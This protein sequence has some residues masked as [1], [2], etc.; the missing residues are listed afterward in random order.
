M[1]VIEPVAFD[2]LPA[3][4]AQAIERNVASR[5]LSSSIQM[6]VWAHRPQAALGWLRLLEEFQT[7]S[8]LGERLRELVRL[9]I[10]SI[11]NCQACQIARKSAEVTEEDIACLTW[12]DP[13]FTPQEQSALHYAE[14]FAA[15]YFAIDDR[16]YADLT[17]HFTTEQI[18]ELGMY[19]ALM[20]AG[21][22]LTY[23]QRAYDEQPSRDERA[24]A[25]AM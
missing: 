19:A 21:G 11:T 5:A 18:V 20:L 24:S 22:R 14:L 9:K 15:D 17:R 13:R 1:S 23:V 3:E 12:S 7:R 10:A 4:L 6:R 25:P 2:K 8:T 16:I